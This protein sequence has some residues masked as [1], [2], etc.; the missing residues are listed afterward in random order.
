VTAFAATAR[1]EL[2]MQ[3]RKR[4][5]WIATLLPL[6]LFLGL[7]AMGTDVGGPARTV[8]DT[9]PK[10]WLVQAVEGFVP[11]LAMVFGVVL[12]D[13][14]VRDRRLRVAALLDVTPANRTARLLGKYLG[15]CA[16]T[17]IPPALAYGAVSVFFA[18]W[19]GKPAALFWGPAAFAVVLLP[20]LLL[21]GSL[22]FLGPLLM[23][24]PVFR[25]LVVG[26]WFWAGTTEVDSQFPSFAG[27]VFSLTMDYPL[28][29]FF[30]SSDATTGTFPDAPL[31]VLRPAATTG[32]AVL[33]IALMLTLAA[34][35]V[36]AARVL[37]AR[38]TD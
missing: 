38:T 11:P 25:V 6:G 30:G 31:N 10:I 7:V 18:L 34:L 27:T 3:L 12:A 36:A 16:G 26:L 4:S 1:Y 32:T 9:D 37:I 19:R 2:R 28:K 15:A 33:A 22:A 24:T 13:R 8:H 23:P 21:A 35:I 5:I 17:A 20:L 29:V 14:L